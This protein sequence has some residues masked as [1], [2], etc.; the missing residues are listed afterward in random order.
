[1]QNTKGQIPNYNTKKPIMQEHY[2]FFLN[3][4][5]GQAKQSLLTALRQ[6]VKR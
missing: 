4:H 5:G 3:F 2:W 6:F 1:M